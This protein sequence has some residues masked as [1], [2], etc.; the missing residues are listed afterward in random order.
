[1]TFADR[2]LQTADRRAPTKSHE[3]AFRCRLFLKVP[4]ADRPLQ[5]ADMQTADTNAILGTVPND[6]LM[7]RRQ[8]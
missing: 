3:H 4:F 7:T 2:P 6:V 8:F 1:M 5:T